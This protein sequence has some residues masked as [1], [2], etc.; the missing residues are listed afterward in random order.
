MTQA[1]LTGPTSPPSSGA[2]PRSIVIFLHGYGSNGADLI[3]LAPY[4]R[5]ACPTLSSWRPTR[6]KPVPA[7]RAVASGGR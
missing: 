6:R 5:D 4:W 3:G 1:L 2:P 7:P